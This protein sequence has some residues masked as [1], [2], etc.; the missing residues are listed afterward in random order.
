MAD[1]SQHLLV[2]DFRHLKMVF[3]GWAVFAAQVF[4]SALSSLGAGIGLCW[5]FAL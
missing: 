5:Q 4:R 1:F 2:E 3:Q